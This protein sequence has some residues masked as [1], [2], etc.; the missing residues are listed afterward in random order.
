MCVCV[1]VYIYITNKQYTLVDLMFTCFSFVSLHKTSLLRS[2]IFL[3]E[4]ASNWRKTN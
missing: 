1:C 2:N 4:P 3:S